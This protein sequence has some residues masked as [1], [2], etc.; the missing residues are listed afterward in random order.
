L[1]EQVDADGETFFATARAHGL[2]GIVSKRI[3]PYRSGKRS[4]WLKI[5]S[6]Q[7]DTFVIVGYMP[8]SRHRI[9][10]LML[11]AEEGGELRYVG[12]VGTGWSEA[13][14]MALKKQLDAFSMPQ[15][16][17]AGVKVKGAV[18]SHPSLHARVAYRGLTSG[19]ELRQASY[20]GLRE[21]E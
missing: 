16:P 5:K 1:S 6:V 15:A 12:A 7:A 2:E 3:D 9:A 11:A 17:V 4:D 14:G 13:E 19:G 8:D 10:Y 18:W 20:R 21:E